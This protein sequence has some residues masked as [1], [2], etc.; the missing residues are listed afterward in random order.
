MPGIILTY[1]RVAEIRD[2]LLQ[3]VRPGRFAE[4]LDFLARTVEIVPLVDVRRRRDRVV[5]LTFDDGYADTARVA[6][7]MLR[8]RSLPATIFVTW[9]QG[10][11]EFW[12]DQLEHLVLDAPDVVPCVDLTID[13]RPFY[14]DIRS[15]AARQRALKALNHRLRP[16]AASDIESALAAVRE[17]VGA[18]GASPCRAHERLAA[19]DL[20]ELAGDSS[21]AV[22]AHG[23]SHTMLSALPPES[24]Q[25]EIET[26]RDEL[27]FVTGARPSQF[28]YPYGTPCSYTAITQRL[29]RRS[30]FEL[31]CTNVSGVVKMR[32]D[33]FALPRVMAYDVDVKTFERRLR[34]VFD[35]GRCRSFH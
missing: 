22:G 10:D 7:P 25:A 4:Q 28:A 35:D 1:H 8:E 34:D 18:G 5:A 19:A 3:A 32:S 16:L 31:A 27:G 29:L 2:P 13:G 14:A 23:A 26:S 15:D 21:V 24:Q 20:T 33:P 17:Q 12:W 6:V 30:G 11:D 9:G